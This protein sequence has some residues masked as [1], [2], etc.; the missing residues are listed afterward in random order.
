[1]DKEYLQKLAEYNIWANE[2]VIGWLGQ[3]T[4]DQ[5]SRKLVGSMDSISATCAHIAGAEKAWG[6][7]FNNIKEPFLTSYFK[8]S[9]NELIPIWKSASNNLLAYIQNKSNA[10]LAGSFDYQNI[11]GEAFTSKYVDALAH[12]FNHSTYHRGQIVN[13]L[14]QVGFTDVGSTDLITFFRI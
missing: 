11:K 1:M 10:D 2:L 8:G 4:D 7:R 14:R 12:V 9:K 5:W 13:Y 3:I 6:E